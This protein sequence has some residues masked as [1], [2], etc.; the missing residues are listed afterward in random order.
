MTEAFRQ[1]LRGRCPSKLSD[2]P[3]GYSRMAR[4]ALWDGKSVSPVL[5]FTRP[6]RPDR[7]SLLTQ[8]LG[9]LSLSGVQEKYSLIQ[10]G[11]RLHVTPAG[12]Q[13][14]HILKPIIESSL[15]KEVDLMPA[16][17]HL[18]MQLAAQ[19]FD[20]RT[21]ENGLIFF[22]DGSPAYITRRFDVGDGG[23]KLAVEDFAALAQRTPATHGSDYK[24][25]GNY[26]EL[27]SLLKRF[28]AAYLV[29]AVKLY[30]LI[31]FNYLVGNG[32]AHY[33]NFSIVETRFGDGMISP[34]YDLL[35]TGLH[36]EDS[37]FALNGGLLPEPLAR[38]KVGEQFRVLGQQAG[39]PVAVVDR[40]FAA[41]PRLSGGVERLVGRSFLPERQQRAYLQAYQ[42]RL[43]KLLRE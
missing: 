40:L 1:Q 33:K 29:E 18:S 39:I 32:D 15:A 8:Q 4:L 31:V 25:E 34:A 30:R 2:S 36:V 42:G 43:R 24:Y 23:K 7:S 41:L 11:S 26:L 13:G 38:G 3:D 14:T 10:E 22:E 12:E 19:V 20:I 17:E 9:R 35:Y 6:D 37:P 5:D 28:F 27:F 21:A 16:N